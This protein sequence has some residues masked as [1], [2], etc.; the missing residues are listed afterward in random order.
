MSTMDV[1]ISNNKTDMIFSCQQWM[2][3]FSITK[4]MLFSRVNDGLN[5]EVWIS[6]DKAGRF[7]S[8][9]QWTVLRIGAKREQSWQI[10][11][12]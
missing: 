6:N 11:V 10:L 9:Q 2:Y 8:C 1:W 5:I 4:P 12:C 7:F 3:G